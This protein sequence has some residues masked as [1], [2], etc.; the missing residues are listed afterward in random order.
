MDSLEH[1]CEVWAG[2]C[3]EGLDLERLWQ[4]RFKYEVELM[5]GV[6][7]GWA[8]VPFRSLRL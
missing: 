1:C 5:S 3:L 6:P 7:L 8:Q 2:E 4:Q